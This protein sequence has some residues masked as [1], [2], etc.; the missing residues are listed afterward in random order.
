MLPQASDGASEPPRVAFATAWVKRWGTAGARYADSKA[1]DLQQTVSDFIACWAT[2]ANMDVDVS[3]IT[4][5]L[6]KCGACVPTAAEEAEAKELEDPSATL[7]DAGVTGTAWLLACVA[8]ACV[9]PHCARTPLTA[10]LR[11][12]AAARRCARRCALSPLL[13]A[14]LLL[15]L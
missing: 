1:V 10:F 11:R 13:C 9:Q 5:R 2:Q 8:G 15:A 12:H 7:G 14:A 4:L 3:L 6:V